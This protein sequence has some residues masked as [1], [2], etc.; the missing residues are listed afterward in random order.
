MQEYLFTYSLDL[1]FNK[2]FLSKQTYFEFNSPRRQ[3]A[4]KSTSIRTF[5]K[6]YKS[7][8]NSDLAGN[9]VFFCSLQWIIYEWRLTSCLTVREQ[10]QTR[11]AT[12]QT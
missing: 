3:E 5:E 12:N 11:L 10:F 2:S 9:W 8:M 1:F 7:F 6:W 4:S